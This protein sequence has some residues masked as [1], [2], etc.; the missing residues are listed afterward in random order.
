MFHFSDCSIIIHVS[1]QLLWFN[2]V[3]GKAKTSEEVEDMLESGNPA[4][5]TSDVSAMC[6]DVG[7]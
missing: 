7:A 1:F 2:S 5:F 3:A 4:I 6:A